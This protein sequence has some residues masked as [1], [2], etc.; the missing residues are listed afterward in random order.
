MIPQLIF[1]FVPIAASIV[2]GILNM[3]S[4]L[5]KC[6]EFNRITEVLVLEAQ[7]QEMVDDFDQTLNP[8]DAQ[9]NL[10]AK[11]ISSFRAD[12]K[13]QFKNGR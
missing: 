9:E 12:V 6:G 4:L 5:T 3:W 8:E 1:V 11:F 2:Y 10:G 7:L 13:S